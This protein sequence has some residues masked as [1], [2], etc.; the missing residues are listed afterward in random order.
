M[1][2]EGP[3]R[4]GTIFIVDDDAAIRDSLALLLGLRGYATQSFAS[5]DDFLTAIDTQARGC[6]LL[7]L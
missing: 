3:P 7:V 6:V 2:A 5:G 4:A 1:S